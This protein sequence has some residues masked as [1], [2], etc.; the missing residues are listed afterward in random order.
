MIGITW[1]NHRGKVGRQLQVFESSVASCV[2]CLCSTTWT[3]VPCT[4]TI[5][6]A[7]ETR[8]VAGVRGLAKQP[9]LP[10]PPQER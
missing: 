10:G 1:D 5:A 3:I 7:P 2:P 9:L 6:S 8:N 4:Q